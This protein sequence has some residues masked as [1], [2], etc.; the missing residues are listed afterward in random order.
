MLWIALFT[1]PLM[2]GVQEI[3]DRTALASGKGLGELI[4]VRFNR[5]LPAGSTIRLALKYQACDNS[6]CFPPAT[7][8]FEVPVPAL[9]RS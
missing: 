2:A 1:F 8:T 5:P 4:V 3:C 6:S 7:K 9:P